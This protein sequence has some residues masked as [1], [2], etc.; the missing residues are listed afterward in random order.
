MAVAED[1]RSEASDGILPVERERA[2]GEM[3]GWKK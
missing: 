2:G 3:L 1:G